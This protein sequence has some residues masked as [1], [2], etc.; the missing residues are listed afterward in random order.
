MITGSK[1]YCTSTNLN[2]K[3]STTS[4]IKRFRE[5]ETATPVD[6][7]SVDDE[8]WGLEDLECDNSTSGVESTD[9]LPPAANISLQEKANSLYHLLTH[10]PKTP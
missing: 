9:G 3:F 2:L 4:K 7:E 10:R 8:V 6:S 5:S 1:I